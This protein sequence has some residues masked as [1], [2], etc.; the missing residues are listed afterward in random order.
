[1]DNIDAKLR[2]IDKEVAE[3][4]N[5]RMKWR[6]DIKRIHNKRFGT[7]IEYEHRLTLSADVKC[8]LHLC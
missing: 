6:N 4:I 8:W 5:V 1:M 3:M 2:K 7:V